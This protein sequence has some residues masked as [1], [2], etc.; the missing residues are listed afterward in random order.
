MYYFVNDYNDICQEEIL[1]ALKE[2]IDE[3]NP[4]Y[5]FD[6]HSARAGE[7]IKSVLED[8]D[9][10]IRFIPGGT[11][12]NILGSSLGMRSQDSIL[13]AKT[14]HIEG[15]EAGSIEACGI[16]IQTIPTKDGKLNR[17]LLEEEYKKYTK[18][19]LSVP[20][21]VYIS[22]STEVGTIYKKKEL[23]EIYDFCKEND[24]YLFID[25][26]R[27]SHAL[28]SDKNDVSYKDL[29]KLCDIFYLGGTK[30]G[31]MLGEAL[32]IVNDELKKD[33]INL[34]KQKGAML[35]K[36]F[37]PGIMFEKAFEGNIYR[38]NADIAFKKAKLL[39]QGLKAKSY[40]LA[41]E[42]ES[43]QIF[44]EIDKEKRLEWEKFAKFE[45]TGEN[46]DKEIVRLVTTYRTSDDEINGFLEKI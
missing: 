23:R 29:T 9:V 41:Y 1:Q 32:V 33:Y 19:Y 34:E 20:K 28:A 46:Q 38:E 37:I 26:A 3:K 8:E 24:L 42:F 39:Y 40:K 13:A 10:Y 5:G 6:N 11:S 31:L 27:L 12:A 25:G 14:A 2:A 43:N 17:K 21:K 22:N 30:N 36:G 7:L 35:A 18:E 4:G 44:V 15:H 16:K 45:I